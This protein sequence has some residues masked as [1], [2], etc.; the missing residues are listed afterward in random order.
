[1]LFDGTFTISNTQIHKFVRN[2]TNEKL[3]T[4]NSSSIALVF[5]LSVYLYIAVVVFL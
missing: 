3:L 2:R 5:P 1:M 4:M